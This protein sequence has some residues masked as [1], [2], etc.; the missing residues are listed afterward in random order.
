MEIMEKNMEHGMENDMD[1][2]NICM[3]YRQLCNT[4][5][6]CQS[7]VRSHAHP[8]LYRVLLWSVVFPDV[9][10]PYTV[11][12]WRALHLRMPRHLTGIELP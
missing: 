5:A 4:C 2:G 8:S 3:G 7:I 1:T 10:L 9:P 11:L 12:R 6:S